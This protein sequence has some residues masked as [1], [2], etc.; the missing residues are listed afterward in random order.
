MPNSQE[1]S[2]IPLTIVMVGLLLRIANREADK[3]AQQPVTPE[4]SA[5]NDV[6]T[7]KDNLLWLPVAAV[8]AIL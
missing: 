8:A 5:I 4:F 2:V 1:I 6:K 3:L 7:K